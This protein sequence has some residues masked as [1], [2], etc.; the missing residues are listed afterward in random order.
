MKRSK[1]A[2][3]WK[4]TIESVRDQA[5]TSEFDVTRQNYRLE[6]NVFKR[7]GKLPV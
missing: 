4:E 5:D 3:F 7:T 1:G 6:L 2:Q